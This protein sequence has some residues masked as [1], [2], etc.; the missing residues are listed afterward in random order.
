MFFFLNW[1]QTNATLRCHNATLN[2]PNFLWA[3]GSGCLEVTR[4]ILKMAMLHVIVTRKI[5]L[6]P[7]TNQKLLLSHDTTFLAPCRLWNLR[8]KHVVCH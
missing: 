1:V 6:S 5:A 3:S 4:Q 2:G 7:V 8:K